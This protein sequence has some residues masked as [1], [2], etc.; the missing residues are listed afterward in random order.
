M[1]KFFLAFLLLLPP[2]II[3]R[4]SFSNFFLQD[5]FILL[6]KFS[7]GNFLFDFIKVVSAHTETHWR[8]IHNL[9]FFLA[10]K[11]FYQNYFYYHLSVFLIHLGVGLLIYKILL[12]LVKSRFSSSVAAVLYLTSSSHF[13]SLY[14]ISGSATSIG[15][16]LFLVCFYMWLKKH[17]FTST[18]FYSMA[19]LASEAFVVGIL[20]IVAF[21]IIY[22][23]SSFE[24]FMS[25]ISL[26]KIFFVTVVYSTVR[27][28]F[29]TPKSTYGAYSPQI[30][31]Q[32][33]GT[34][35]YYLLRTAG[36]SELS[37]DF[38][39]SVILLILLA[40]VFFKLIKLLGGDNGSKAIYLSLALIAIGLFPFVLLPNHLSPHYMNISIWG[41]AM[42]IGIVLG[43]RKILNYLIIFLF[44]F[45]SLV[46]VYKYENNSWITTRAKISRAYLNGIGA[47][48]PPAGSTL[49]F[50]D[51]A[52]SSS[53]EAY[54][55]LG[56]GTAIKFWFK[57]KNYKTCFVEF[58]S[59]TTL[60]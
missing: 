4:N 10:G 24:S 20:V 26:I 22:L 18:L 36:F 42:M 15:M 57:D 60:P 56:T 9:Y 35:K 48:N 44:F 12:L 39:I 17:Y 31:I 55:S 16:F 46:N 14:W 7:Q 30:S 29:L 43:E 23:R 13:A 32:S 50:G 51:N 6:S 45:V 1:K 8:P 25:K 11:F 49:V 52:I 27:F 33:I 40:I 3:F 34:I 21:E 38:L 19:L 54:I 41:F 47:K 5:D 2:L 58:E 37:G 53:Y 59:C 28:V